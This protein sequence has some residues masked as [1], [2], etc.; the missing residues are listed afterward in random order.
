MVHWGVRKMV[1][2]Y[3]GL[4]NLKD[5]NVT[6]VKK[7]KYFAIVGMFSFTSLLTGCNERIDNK[8]TVRDVIET[9]KDSS[10]IDE[11]LEVIKFKPTKKDKKMTFEMAEEKYKEA[12]ADENIE[13]CNKYLY[14]MS[15]T[16]LESKIVSYY[17]INLDGATDISFKVN[18]KD[19]T[20]AYI[21]TLTYKT[22]EDKVVPGGIVTSEEFDNKIVVELR[23]LAEDVALNM[24]RARE[25]K[26]NF[27][28]SDGINY[29]IDDCYIKL[30]DFALGDTKVGFSFLQRPFFEVRK[31]SS[32]KIKALKLDK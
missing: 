4:D 23:V 6:L 17:N 7:A 9:F 12:R 5:K 18:K 24:S 20:S 22:E 16:L 14:V 1:H 28:E 3:K 25:G 31:P 27:E 13:D 8:Y 29:N 2:L 10:T 26:L 11:N 30:R 15:K 32:K 19:S 21:A